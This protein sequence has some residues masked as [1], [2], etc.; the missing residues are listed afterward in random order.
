M[1]VVQIKLILY[2]TEAGENRVGSKQ[3][4][5]EERERERRAG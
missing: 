4:R 3:E 2:I 5:E 1:L